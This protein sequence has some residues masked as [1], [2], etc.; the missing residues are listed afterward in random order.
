MAERTCGGWNSFAD[1]VLHV[2]TIGIKELCSSGLNSL[3]PS[4][5]GVSETSEL[6]SH[7]LRAKFLPQ[8]NCA[9]NIVV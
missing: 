7:F 2:L 1:L 9:R 4:A 5:C 8:L 3:G 6:A